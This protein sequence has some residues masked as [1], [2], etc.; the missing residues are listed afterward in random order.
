ML[1]NLFLIFYKILKNRSSKATTLFVVQISLSNVSSSF[2]N[3]SKMFSY[4]FPENKI[5]LKEQ[6]K[7]FPWNVVR[8]SQNSQVISGSEN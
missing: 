3:S 4:F 8:K 1:G 6:N 2:P 5:V 7:L